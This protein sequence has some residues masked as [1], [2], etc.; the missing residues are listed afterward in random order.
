MFSEMKTVRTVWL[1]LKLKLRTLMK[2]VA[3]G[4]DLVE[5]IEAGKFVTFHNGAL[6]HTPLQIFSNHS[7]NLLVC[8][9][10]SHIP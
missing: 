8:S 9:S 3:I 1:Q 10:S 6:P 7:L 4:P 2:L 5:G